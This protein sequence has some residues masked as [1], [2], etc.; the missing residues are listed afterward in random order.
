MRFVS[1]NAHTTAQQ[2]S[3]QQ[4]VEKTESIFQHILSAHYPTQHPAL[5]MVAPHVAL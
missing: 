3:W 5:S 4:I 2:L 1:E